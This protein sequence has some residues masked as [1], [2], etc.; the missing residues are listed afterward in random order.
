MWV[1]SRTAHDV[2]Q[3]I[4]IGLVIVAVLWLWLFFNEAPLWAAEN[5]WTWWAEWVV[6]DDGVTLRTTWLGTC[7]WLIPPPL[8]LVLGVVA[9]PNMELEKK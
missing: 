3:A 9:Y 4:S 2:W 8:F 5:D 6:S 1:R 7:I